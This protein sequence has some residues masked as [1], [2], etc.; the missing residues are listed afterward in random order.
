[1]S[2]PEVFNGTNKISVLEIFFRRSR[3]F[4]IREKKKKQIS[5]R[6][7]EKNLERRKKSRHILRGARING[8]TQKKLKQEGGVIVGNESIPNNICVHCTVQI[9]FSLSIVISLSSLKG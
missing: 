5:R 2:P 9:F 7:P 3:V 4:F 8:T 6:S 1:M